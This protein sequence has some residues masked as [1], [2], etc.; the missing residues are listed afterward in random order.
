MSL[1]SAGVRHV[2]YMDMGSGI[3]GLVVWYIASGAQCPR[4]NTPLGHSGY[5]SINFCS[6]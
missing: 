3:A 4:I 2:T 5:V 1:N 6:L